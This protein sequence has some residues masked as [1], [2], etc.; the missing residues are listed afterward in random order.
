MS[1]FNSSKSNMVGVAQIATQLKSDITAQGDDFIR[2]GNAEAVTVS[3]ESLDPQALSRH[4]AS[5]GDVRNSII[6]SLEAA[7]IEVD[8]DG[9]GLEAASIIAMGLGNPED[10]H[11]AATRA[12]V[13]AGD[14]VTVIP[15]AQGVPA[16]EAFDQNAIGNYQH[17]SLAFNL[18]SAQQDEFGETL[19]PTIVLTAETGGLDVTIE[20]TV[21]HREVR[22]ATSGDVSD[23]N[24]KKVLDAVVDHTI[25]ESDTTRI[26]PIV[27]ADGSNAKFFADD[28]VVGKQTIVVDGAEITTAPLKPGVAVD[29]LAVSSSSP[30][31][32]G[33]ELTDEDSIDSNAGLDTIYVQISDAAATKTSVVAIKVKNLPRSSFFKS[34]EGKSEREMSIQFSTDT[35]VMTS[36]RQDIA[37]AAAEALASLN[38]QKLNV[39]LQMSGTLDLETGELK[40]YNP[41]PSVS[42]LYAADGTQIAVNSGAGKALVDNLSFELVGYT[43]EAYHSNANLRHRGILGSHTGKVERYSIGFNAPITAK[44]PIN[45]SKRRNASDLK[46]ITAISRTRNANEAVSKLIAR[47]DMLK[48]YAEAVQGDMPL[49]EIEGAGR[50]L[51]NPYYAELEIDMAQVINSTKSHEKAA[52]VSDTLVNAIRS[53]AYPMA[54]DSNYQT[55]LETI[56]N[57]RETKPRLIIATDSVLQRHI[58]VSG[59]E[60]TASIGMDHKVV[61]SPD[62]RMSGTIYLTFGR[63]GTNGEADPL[64]FGA[65]GWIPEMVSSAQ[66]SRGGSTAKV[67]TVQTRNRH[68]GLLPVMAKITVK[69]LDKVLSQKVS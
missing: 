45:D 61:T 29:L 33:Q 58:L 12:T 14:N 6:A 69:N 55:A 16:M 59:D 43:L 56:T 21:V 27:L 24:K 19:F 41:A 4:E 60:R 20:Q 11:S 62:K 26:Y 53:L 40:L 42:G 35:V 18:E 2:P 1:R 10:Y 37:G 67:T 31:N 68:I 5:F 66:V 64:S 51:V 52:D 17:Y 48:S 23:F 65:H 38:D 50:H 8:Q 34:P 49:P 22:R 44:A 54:Q 13:T 3:I 15:D 47:A 46:T 57:G 28:A 30:L 25:L 36:G 9:V 39:S 32:N 7:N 63:E